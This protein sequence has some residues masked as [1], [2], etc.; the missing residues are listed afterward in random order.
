[1]A[2]PDPMT[3]NPIEVGARVVVDSKR[4]GV[5]ARSGVVTAMS[6]SLVHVRWDSGEE[7]S[8]VPAAG[9]MRLAD[10]PQYQA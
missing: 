5:E 4:I 10:P 7:T 6:G 8:F 2:L 9:S 1:M 3:H